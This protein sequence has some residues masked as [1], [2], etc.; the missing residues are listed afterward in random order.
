VQA[1]LKRVP[2]RRAAHVAGAVMAIVAVALLT[3]RGFSLRASLGD[4]LARIPW[5]HFLLAVSWYA[6]GGLLLGW[7]WMLLVRTG[8]GSRVEARPLVASHLRSQ[9][10]KYLPGNVVHFAWRHLAARAQG[11]D[12][13]ALALALALESLLLLGAG[14][15]LA[16]SVVADPRIA[17]RFPWAAK[18]AW[19][20]PLLPALALAAGFAF[21][22]RR[23]VGR[24]AAPRLALAFALCVV[25][26]L[27]AALALRTLAAEPRLLPFTA[28]CGWLS[29]AWAVGY[30]TP[31]A[32]G[33]IG[34]REAVLVLGLDP[35][36]G[37]ADALA[38]AV[39]YRL[40]TVVADGV[41]AVAGF[42]SW[43]GAAGAREKR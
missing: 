13:R 37:E 14:A 41:L 9:L 30:V 4:A 1:S 12:H 31:G 26:M 7:V 42:L 19:L 10:G 27:L 16:L 43:R 29:L 11:A 40:V 20:A 39:A 36:F 25:F 6:A 24:Q 2:W 15:L 18:L 21:A 3:Q 38:L 5:S 17:A 35:V 33:G 32:P 28:W 8:V 23:G 22:R 34:L